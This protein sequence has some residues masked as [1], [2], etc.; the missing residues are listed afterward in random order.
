MKDEEGGTWGRK[1]GREG[2]VGREA[3][4]LLQLAASSATPSERPR[5]CCEQEPAQEAL[6]RKE[7]DVPYERVIVHVTWAVSLA[8]LD[9]LQVDHGS[10]LHA[11]ATAL[12]TG[13]GS[14]EFR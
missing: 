1:V 8:Q 7:E 3:R 2:E 13:G 12:K 5:E 9:G 11:R 6:T 4:P 10:A 14:G